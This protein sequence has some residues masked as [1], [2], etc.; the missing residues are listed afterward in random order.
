MFRSW[1]EYV[2]FMFKRSLYNHT[3]YIPKCKRE[4]GIEYTHIGCIAI[5]C[6]NARIR[7]E[8]SKGTSGCSR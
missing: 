5:S 4:K 7:L 3:C 8:K 6:K 2:S 1:I